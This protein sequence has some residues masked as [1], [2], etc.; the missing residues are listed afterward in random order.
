[1]EKGIIDGTSP[2]RAEFVRKRWGI[3]MKRTL[4]ILIFV[5]AWTPLNPAQALTPPLSPDVLQNE[6]TLVVEGKITGP[7]Q[8]LSRIE[9]SKCAD[10]YRYT[11]PLQVTKVLK[12]EAKPGDVLTVNFV[13]Y[14]YGKSECVGDQG[15]A[16]QNTQQGTYYLKKDGKDG[17]SLWHWSA[18]KVK[19]AGMGDLP[20]CK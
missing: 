7:I 4:A 11:T 12:G 8:C 14:D 18:V 20:A 1:M 3:A 16:V 9:Q 10:V 6:A 19:A 17:Y 13:H 5:A 2:E 15:P